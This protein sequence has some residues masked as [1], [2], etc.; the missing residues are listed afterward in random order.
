M[1]CAVIPVS[2]AEAGARQPSTGDARV[3]VE[4]MRGGITGISSRDEC[5]F[6]MGGA[7]A[8]RG[9]VDRSVRWLGVANIYVGICC[10]WIAGKGS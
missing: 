5:T 10:G 6:M 7:R 9:Y 3:P 2:F 4:G 8:E 1:C